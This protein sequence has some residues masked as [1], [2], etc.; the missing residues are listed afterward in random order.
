[1]RQNKKTTAFSDSLIS[2]AL[3]LLV[4]SFFSSGV[5]AQIGKC[6]C[7]LTQ[8]ERM[9]HIILYAEFIGDWLVC[10]LLMLCIK[11]DRVFFRKLGRQSGNSSKFAVFGALAGFGMNGVCVL[12]AVLRQDITLTYKGENVLFLLLCFAAVCIQAGAEELLFRLYGYQKLKRGCKNEFLAA[13]VPAVA[14]S[15]SHVFNSGVALL[16]LVNIVLIGVFYGLAIYYLDSL[17]FC[18]LHHTL[19]NYTQNILFGLPNSG[20]VSALSVFR[21]DAAAAKDSFCYNSAF[22]VEGTLLCSSVI[23][24]GIALM[25]LFGRREREKRLAKEKLIGI[26]DK[27]DV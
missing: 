24:A 14:F 17:W 11:R 27:S 7:H 9:L 4:I 13:V 16:P 12:A 10:F 5:D 23:T 6:L 25:I 22:G 20:F 8:D 18:I 3:F 2:T 15:L 19:W 1:M 21:M 26:N